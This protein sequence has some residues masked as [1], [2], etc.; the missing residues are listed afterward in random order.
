M[1]QALDTLCECALKRFAGAGFPRCVHFVFDEFA[2]IGT[3]PD[4][5]RMITVTRSRNIAVSMI[6][7]SLSQLDENYGENNAAT[8][9]N[10]CDTMLYL[11]GKSAD[12]NQKIAEMIGKQTVAN[13]SVNDSRGNN[14]TYTHNYGLIERDLMQGSEISRM[15][16]DEALVLIKRGASVQGQEVRAFVAPPRITAGKG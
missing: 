6:C 14:P 16:K 12:T 13:V 2:N 10:A 9:V 15:P 11:G 3:I 8:I 7:Q 1:Q 4:F 5:E